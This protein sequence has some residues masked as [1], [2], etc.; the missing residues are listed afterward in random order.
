MQDLS[1]ENLVS[2][3]V[4]LTSLNNRLKTIMEPRTASAKARLNVMKQLTDNDI[5]TTAMIAPII[6]AIND[7]EIERLLDAVHQ[8]GVE[9]A[10]YVL[11]RL[12]YELK[13]CL[14]TGWNNTFPTENRKY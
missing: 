14:A 12:P 9:Q 2:V 4:S 3:G 8:Q 1:K 7:K 11:L 10:G 5:A 6:P 13:P